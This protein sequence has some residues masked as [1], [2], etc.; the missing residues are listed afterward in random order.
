MGG[1]TRLFGAKAISRNRV[2]PSDVDLGHKTSIYC[3]EAWN[4]EEA[5][6]GNSTLPV[7]CAGLY[8]SNILN[9]SWFMPSG[10]FQ[11]T[12]SGLILLLQLSI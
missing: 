5:A 10:G 2:R 3:S 12:L 11:L 6:M 7:V 8:I 9:R 4:P 1:I